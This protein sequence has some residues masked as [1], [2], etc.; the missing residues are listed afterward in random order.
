MGIKIKNMIT[1]IK[2]SL[3]GLNRRVVKTEERVSELEDQQ[4]LSNIKDKEKK[5]ID[6]K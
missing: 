5:K 1:E 2:N 4:K 3:S 6:I